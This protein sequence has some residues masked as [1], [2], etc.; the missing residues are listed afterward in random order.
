MIFDFAAPK[1]EAVC[2]VDDM[3]ASVLTEMPNTNV[4][5]GQGWIALKLEYCI[6]ERQLVR[7]QNR[8]SY[9]RG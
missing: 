5:I 3:S 9:E 1:T 8:L 7:S 4:V 2:L 6:R